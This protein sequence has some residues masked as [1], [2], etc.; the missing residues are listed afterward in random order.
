V[1][2]SRPGPTISSDTARLDSPAGKPLSH[3]LEEPEPPPPSVPP[4]E[5]LVPS[6]TVRS[7]EYIV[8]LSRSDG[9]PKQP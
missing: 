1:G 9:L 6:Q 7:M 3:G 4:L 5:S 2:S 8:D